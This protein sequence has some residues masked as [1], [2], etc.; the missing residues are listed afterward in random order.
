MNAIE[1]YK[2]RYFIQ[3]REKDWN[4]RL[5]LINHVCENDFIYNYRFV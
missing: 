5:L 4:T 1:W 3:D 2:Y